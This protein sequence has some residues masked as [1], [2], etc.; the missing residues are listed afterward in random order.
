MTEY[1][2]GEGQQGVGGTI[3]NALGQCF[4]SCFPGVLIAISQ[5]K[6][7]L[8]QIHLELPF[9]PLPVLF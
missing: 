1:L 7:N 4:K 8:G 9:A 2:E 5:G 6:G 3:L